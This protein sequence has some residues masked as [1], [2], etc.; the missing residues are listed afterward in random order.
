MFWP[1]LRM[2]IFNSQEN[3]I[4]GKWESARKGD[5]ASDIPSKNPPINIMAS[6]SQE[7]TKPAVAE[8]H[9]RNW[10]SL[11]GTYMKHLELFPLETVHSDWECF[12][13]EKAAIKTSYDPVITTWSIWNDSNYRGSPMKQLNQNHV[14]LRKLKPENLTTRP[15][16]KSNKN[17]VKRQEA[18][19]R[20]NVK[21]VIPSNAVG[22]GPSS[23]RSSDLRSIFQAESASPGRRI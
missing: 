8:I 1:R 12:A 7:P 3:S 4:S 17:L 19:F 9:V 11:Q 5:L 10:A 2:I 13:N 23:F 6:P 20:E 21:E 14:A 15:T 22:V 16:S 18:V